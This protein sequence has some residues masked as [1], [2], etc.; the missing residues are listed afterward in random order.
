MTKQNFPAIDR[1]LQQNAYRWQKDTENILAAEPYKQAVSLLTQAEPQTEQ[2]SAEQRQLALEALQQFQ[3]LIQAYPKSD[4]VDHALVSI[5]AA[6][7]IR[8]AWGDALKA[9]EQLTARYAKQ[10]PKD[11]GLQ[12]LLAYAQERSESIRLFLLQKEK[13][14]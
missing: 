11:A 6:H 5:G 7:E 3:S 10:P 1:Q 13:F 2:A 4:Y 9:Y 12:K 8:E 14:D